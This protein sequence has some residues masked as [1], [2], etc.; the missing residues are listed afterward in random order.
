MTTNQKVALFPHGDSQ[1]AVI[2]PVEAESFGEEKPAPVPDG[3]PYVFVDFDKLPPFD[4]F[5]EAWEFDFSDIEDHTQEVTVNLEK[6]KEIHRKFLRGARKPLLGKLDVE[7]MQCLE[8]GLPTDQVQEKKQILRDVTQTDALN[9]A[10]SVEEIK[11]SWPT[12]VLGDS[13]YVA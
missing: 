12:D 3:V 6:A 7:F 11:L 10:Q 4:V 1:V 13:P 5:Q 9:D 2:I 8:Q